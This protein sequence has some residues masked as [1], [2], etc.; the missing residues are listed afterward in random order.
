MM[1]FLACL[2]TGLLLSFFALINPASAAGNDFLPAPNDSIGFNGT[3]NICQGS[4]LTLTA[5]FA[6]TGSSFQWVFNGAD[7]AGATASTYVA[8]ASGTYTVKVNDNGTVLQWP[9]MT[10]TVHPYPQAGFNFSP[11]GQCGNVPVQFT[12]TTAG[13]TSYTW[14]FDDPN[15]GAANNTS[16]NA[17]PQHA[18]AGTPGNGNQTFNVKL[19]AD[20]AGCKDS[21]TQ[22]VTVKQL[23][24]TEMG[25][26]GFTTY[27]GLPYFT[28]CASTTSNFTFT[29]QS[30]TATTNTGYVIKWGDNTPDFTSASWVSTTH[31]YGI[32]TYQLLFIVTGG[33]GCVDTTI[34][35]IFVGNNPAVGLNNPGNTF[36]CSGTSLT[37]PISG[38][39]NNPPGTVYTVFFNDGSAPTS[40][41]HPAPANVSHLFT[42]GSCGTNSGSFV[43]SFQAS[44]QAS[45][46]CGT[47][48]ASVVPIYVSQ[49]GTALFA[50]SPKDTVCTSNTVTFTNTSTNAYGVSSSGVCSLGKGV[51]SISP[52]TG[53]TLTSGA[54]GNT[55]NSTDPSLWQNGT[56]AINVNFSTPGVYSIKLKVGA[57]ALCGGDSI[58]RTIC[59]NPAPVAGFSLSANQGCGPLTVTASNNSNT[60]T[61]GNNTYQW[62]VTYS[63]SAGCTPNSSGY[64]YTS[65]TSATSANP[66]FL[67]TNPGVYT[68]SLI[69]RSPA[70]PCIS[71]PVTQ[72]ITVKE[73]PNVTVTSPT[74]VCQNG[75]ISPTAVVNNCYS[76]TAATYAWSF[77]GG[78][79]ASSTS[80]IPG[81]ISYTNSGSYTIT[82]DVTNECGTTTVTK[83]IT[84]NAAPDV[85]VPA[86]QVFCAGAP[87]GGFSFSSSVAGTTYSWTN[88]NTAIGL[89][90]SGNGSIPNF[91]AVNATGSPITATITVLPL[92]GCAGPSQSFT[93]TVNPRPVAPAVSS[94]VVYCLNET[95]QTLSATAASGNTLTWYT[96]AALTN[97]NT[98]APL[99]STAVAGT[100][101]HWVTQT[102]SFSCQSPASTISVVV[103]PLLVGNT[104]GSNQTICSNTATSPLTPQATITGGSGSYTYQ[105]QQ[106]SDGINWTIVTGAT[107]GSYSPGTVTS[108]VYY[109][110]IVNSAACT[111]TSN[112]VTISVLGSLSNIDIA[113]AQTICAGTVPA[114]LTGQT[115][116]GGS[117]SFSYQ[118]ESSP[119][120][121]TWTPITGETGVDHQP[122]ALN[123]TT[124]Y[125]RKTTSGSC[126]AYSSVV[127]ITVNPIPV[128]TTVTNKNFCTGA[129]VAAINF[130][131]TPAANASYTWTNSEPL[132]GLAASG[133]GALPAFTA[134][135]AGNPKQ[136]LIATISV[137]PVYTANTV[138]CSGTPGSFTITVLPQISVGPIPDT[139]VCT[140]TPLPTF[141]PAHDAA[142]YPNSSVSFTWTVSGSGTNL[143]AGSGNSIPAVST[144]NTGSTDLVTTVT[145]TPVYHFNNTSCN[146]QPDVYTITVK[147]GTPSAN[148]GADTVLCNAATY[149]MQ[150]LL[151]NGTTGNWTQLGT[152]T[153]VITN[154][155]SP[156]S[157]ITGLT[158]GTTY[159]F[160]WNVSGF[161]SCPPSKDTVTIK[162]DPPIVNTIDNNTQTICATQSTTI[163]G[164]IP[165]GGNGSYTY[166]W[167]QSS[168]GVTWTN[169]VGATSASLTITPASTIFVRRLVFSLP[170]TSTSTSTQIVVQPALTNNTIAASQAVCINTAAATING[171]Q[172]SGG[173]GTYLY[174]WQQSTNGGSSWT[175]I[176]GATAQNFTPGV[177]SVTTLYRRLV[178]TA[179][180]SGPQSSIS[181]A[182]TITVN[183]DADAVFNP[184]KFDG[185]I[186][187][188][189]TPAIVNLQASNANSQYLWY[190]DNVLI[191]SGAT[192]PG[193]TM[194][195]PDDTVTI[196]LVAISA[197]GCLSDSISR[198]FHTY[199]VPLPSFTLSDTVGCGPLTVSFNNTT[200][201]QSFFTYYW[202][203]GNGQTSTLAQPGPVTFAT[204]PT[205]GDTVYTVTL[206]V[207]SQCDTIKTTGTIRV[208]SKPKALFTPNISV[209]CSPM[210]V[211]FTNTSAGIGNSYTWH[212]GDGTAPLSSSGGNVT[213]T[214]YT[215]V[216]DT[217]YVK[218]VA[219][220]GCG[221]D[222]I[223]YAIVASPN[224][225]VLDFAINGNQFSGC[226][227]H[228]VKF[229][230][231]SSGASSFTWNFGDG[232]TLNTIKNID[233]V[234][235]TYL[236]PGNYT[237]TLFASNG[238]SDTTGTENIVIHPSPQ[239]AFAP[240]VTSACI[241]VPISFTNNSVGASSYLWQFGDG[242]NSSLSNPTHAYTQPG[243]YTIRL[244]SYS[245]NSSGTAC[246]DTAL[247]QVQITGSQPGW[248]TASDTVGN[249]APFT[250]SF[251][252]QNLPS[253]TAA[254]N[255]GDGNNG[256]GN[257]VSHTYTVP[258]TYTVILNAT[259]PG[260]CLYQTI[261]T[262][263]V[264]GPS[265]TWTHTTG[266]L[267]NNSAASFQVTANNYD[268]IT[269]NFGDGQSLTTTSNSVFHVYINGGNYFP[270]AIIKNNAGCTVP[271]ATVDTIKV[272]K[273]K[274]G[275]TATQQGF[276]GF[277]T[278][279]FSDTT[280]AFFG[281]TSVA[282]NFGDGNNGNGS[283]VSHNYF[284]AGNYAVQMIVTGKS[285][286][287]DTVVKQVVITIK[288]RPVVTIGAP[289][290]ACTRT[291]VAF[292]STVQSADAVSIMQWTL[293]N[294]VTNS[295][296]SFNY[297][298]LQPGTYN[299]RLVA[300][301]VNGCFDTAYASI[302]INPSPTVL[303]SADFNLCRG[304]STPLTA[305]G[306]GVTQWSWSPLQGLSCY[307]CASPVASPL[308]TTPYVVQGTN[309]F[310]CTGSDTVVIT[311]IQPFKLTLSSADS[312]CIGESTNLLASG[313]SSYSWSPANG[314]NNTTVAN[315][316]ASPT[317]TTIYRVVGYDG[318]NCFTD[319]GFVT[320][321]VG[322]YP[323]INLGPDLLLATGTLQPLTT[324]VQNGPITKWL[325]TPSAD[326]SCSTCPLPIATI[327]KDQQFIVKG[328]TAYG[329]SDTDTLMIKTFCQSA[330]VFIPN[331]FTPD[332]DGYNDVLM[333]RASGIALVKTF[334]IF[335]RWGEVVFEKGNFQP[336]LPQYGWN[337][338][339]KG[340]DSGPDVFVY[341][342]E[343]VCENGTTYTYKGNV[344]ILK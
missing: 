272:D 168:D 107:G 204:N 6:P 284:A 246:V 271:L 48:A 187:F 279:N 245:Q 79:P 332:G 305:T 44:I 252:N 285:G 215:G 31:T 169:I 164:S 53:W 340:A 130:T 327:R 263:K 242:I 45:N 19:V 102:N 323:V 216:Q 302:V 273:I 197:F 214:F 287:R 322:Q 248:F 8:T 319:T 147:P 61:C 202:T 237:I 116:A 57:T 283:N 194:T 238:C 341:T 231:N 9:S 21:S 68:V 28:Q 85:T 208:K 220:N 321:A 316:T 15:S 336:N 313:A 115:P 110:R 123:A 196:K 134:Q 148:A 213:H 295:N 182:V 109:R 309:S 16:T 14:Y 192:F 301:T 267:C 318:F 335:N 249:C 108:T 207:I 159:Q 99:P 71:A 93:I 189:I 325:W 268:S 105:W 77:P 266:Y 59:V 49:K 42:I 304:S 121:I 22:P 18:F 23:P 326:L 265:G 324:T 298:F 314:L 84:V 52:A 70:V 209:G 193:F 203:F 226:A 228:T 72:T 26:T 98:T 274:A 80:A 289:S 211:I 75:S 236:L 294:G 55:F 257:T 100:T 152:T 286:C 311:V 97:G 241:G 306:N 258:G 307:N 92:N 114:L 117:G 140:G 296:A 39:G 227:P 190:A 43:N 90:A 155:S 17:N 339:I 282:W 297:T 126:T 63:N 112:I 177:L 41:P 51:W 254:W 344:S 73:K 184:T 179:L 151:P 2:Q 40:F 122:A 233:T 142:A 58:V 156:V 243:T 261:R 264:L 188:V 171:A 244:I 81:S 312:I 141:A 270:T 183:P 88:S 250:V 255:F 82:L 329:C 139:T 320:V 317:V 106:S 180:C 62:S 78:T 256:S 218:L 1:K 195:Q 212:F 178:S 150:A 217:F 234:S 201:E 290:T 29:N 12:N 36:I 46:P 89:A 25:G 281:V 224:Q 47:S 170:C 315:P 206:G 225:V 125:R 83:N 247:Q 101:T 310:G 291:P 172:P 199:K 205:F 161:A 64:T 222:S 65:G 129:S 74:A 276:C 143:S 334:R 13:A 239:A 137:T 20:I 167:Q 330:Q 118:W 288:N 157:S 111:D 293:S 277:T 133:A 96:S 292:S 163:N 37:F 342:A 95:P 165:T 262:I 230:N 69:T 235:H 158:A 11:S 185:C 144:L 119:N 153:A 146:G 337:G 174:Q 162:I 120:G 219:V 278:V 173:N 32:G 149:N 30:S 280:H 229:I 191:G 113:S 35:Y 240:S 145:V 34:Y 94:P 333:V 175:N 4:S 54:F 223:T 160:V 67:F 27:N 154:P 138:A 86:A 5:N 299:I 128:L 328:T 166:Q 104:I 76:T 338:K 176:A 300:G 303:A 181:N 38:T 186:P 91:T 132:I 7:I 308:T 10:L 251:S 33:N 198:E 331:A 260:G 135:N 221:K 124:H 66:V 259:A 3:G 103:H 50:I 24:G 275:Y 200:P 131:S 232:N 87:T 56:T 136:P 343:V 269:Y 60:P 127:I 210:T 253:A